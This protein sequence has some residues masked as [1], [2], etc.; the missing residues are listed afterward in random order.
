MR[1]KTDRPFLVP[2]SSKDDFETAVLLDGLF[3]WVFLD[4]C[5]AAKCSFLEMVVS[6]CDKNYT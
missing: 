6:N 5:A 4:Y 3:L 2:A 1:N